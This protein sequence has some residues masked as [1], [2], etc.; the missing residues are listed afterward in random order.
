MSLSPGQTIAHYTITEKIGQGGM[1]EVYRATDTKLNRDVALKVLPEAFASDTQRMARFSREAQVLASLN[2]PSIAGIYGLEQ[3]GST[4]AIAMELVKGETLAARISKGAIPLEEALNIAL[5]IAEALEA[6]HEKGIIHRDLKPAN[7][8]VTPEGT[9]KVLDF[10]LAKAMEPGTS[11]EGDLSQS[12]TLTMQATQAGIILGTAAYMSPEQASGSSTDSRADIWSFGVVLFEM[13]T[14]QRLFTGESAVEVMS[15]VMRDEPDSALLP[16]ATPAAIRKLLRRSL[17]KDRKRRLHA[18]AD[19]RFE[20]EEALSGAADVDAAVGV[21]GRVASGW[22]L[23]LTWILLGIIAA[24]TAF[25]VL[26]P[27]TEGGPPRTVARFSI[28]LPPEAPLAPAAAMPLGVGRKSLALSPNGKLLVYVAYVEGRNL[29]YLRDM[30]SG[31]YKP[32]PGTQNAHSPFFSPDAKWVGFFAD[33]RLKKISLRGSETVVLCEATLGHGGSWGKDGNLYFSTDYDSGVYWIAASGG[34]PEVVASKALLEDPLFYP[35]VLPHSKGVLFHFSRGGLGVLDLGSSKKKKVL[36]QGTSVEHVPTGHIVFTVRG[37]ILAA[38]FDLDGLEVTGRP[39]L[40]LDGVRHEQNGPAQFTVS[41][42]GTFVFAEGPDASVGALIWVDRQGNEQPILGGP[43]GEHLEFPLSPDGKTIALSMADENGSDIWLY[44]TE[45]RTSTRLTRDGSSSFPVWSP[46]GTTIY[47]GSSISGVPNV[48][49]IRVDGT[50]GSEQVTDGDMP[51]HPRSISADEKTLL[52]HRFTE[53]GIDI[54]RL[55]L[56]GEN[57]AEKRSGEPIPF[58][59]TSSL[60]LFPEFSPDGRWVAYTSDETRS[61]EVYVTRYPGPGGKVR[62]SDAGGEEPVWSHDGRQ[63][64]YRI[65]SQ[66]FVV[67]ITPG[68]DF[69]AGRPRLAFEGSYINTWGIS[70]EVGLDGKRFLVVKGSEQNRT[71]T[72]FSVITNF[73][74]L[75]RRQ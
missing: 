51:L 7:V 4:N 33:D 2:H 35:Y 5:Q 70:Y 37:K 61:W 72:R 69:R 20:I 28:E 17:T 30:E 54:W 58:L 13:L 31:E 75:I 22:S 18:I 19:A 47:Y 44:D 42:D 16:A 23:P 40:L 63:L 64:F 73:F 21:G 53:T 56:A 46:N 52:L 68:E 48:Y 34:K 8:I 10:G 39:V 57:G 74:E 11:A 62:I 45:R 15:R 12:P 43:S 14:G 66:W 1:G 24:L 29:L 32:L 38:P 65:G 27:R 49:R 55:Q 59:T 9:A 41:Q 26:Y 67:D 71:L 36:G 60:E 25:V 50:K 3:E 6:A